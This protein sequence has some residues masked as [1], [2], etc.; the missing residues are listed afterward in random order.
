MTTDVDA[1]WP[2]I[3]AWLREHA[4][5]TAEPLGPPATDEAIAEAETEVGASFPADLRAWFR[6]A[7]GIAT[8][9]HPDTLIPPHF[10]PYSLRQALRTRR[11]WLDVGDSLLGHDG[12]GFAYREGENDKSAGLGCDTWLPRWLP[13]AGD[14][15]GTDLFVD[16]RGGQEHGCLMTYDKVEACYGPPLWR[17]VAAMV[18]EIADALVL[19]SVAVGCRSVVSA[20]NR[21]GW[22]SPDGLWLNGFP[23]REDSLR[24]C[25]YDIVD[26]A[27]ADDVSDPVQAEMIVARVALVIDALLATA[28]QLEAAAGGHHRVRYDDP[29]PRDEAALRAYAAEHGGRSGMAERIHAM[30]NRLLLLIRPHLDEVDAP[31]RRR[32]RGPLIHATVREHGDVVIDGEVSWPGLVSGLVWLLLQQDRRL[33]HMRPKEQRTR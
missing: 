18:A 5:T 21:L 22:R 3:V 20:D 4:P 6:Q 10:R 2:R 27:P 7:D 9:S 17:N 29:D 26:H 32:G 33:V 25:L 24:H 1:T 28:E 19:D 15:G 11:T 16:L 8:A 31:P 23:L 30:G 14:G 12:F 13:I